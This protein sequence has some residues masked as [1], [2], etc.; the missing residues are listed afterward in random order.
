MKNTV[1]AYCTQPG[2]GTRIIPPGAITAL[3]VVHFSALDSVFA[4]LLTAL[5]VLHSATFDSVFAILLQ[6]S[7]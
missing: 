5:Q 4:I 2:R 3:Q 6:T 1:V 7:L